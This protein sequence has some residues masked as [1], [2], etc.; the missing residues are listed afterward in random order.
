[1]ADQCKSMMAKRDQMM[2]DM[3]AMNSELDQ[4]I[5]AMNSASGSAMAAV[6][7]EFASQRKQMQQQKMMTMQ[8]NMM[9]HVG[10]HMMAG[11]ESMMNCPMMKSAPNSK[12]GVQ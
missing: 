6:I 9:E 7:N 3:K 8:E 10:A 1:M 5:A 12:P 4:K 2:A 11:K